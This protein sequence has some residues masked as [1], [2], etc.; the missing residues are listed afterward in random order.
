METMFND[1]LEKDEKIVKTYKPNKQKY[2]FSV[3]FSVII[4]NLWWYFMAM[5]FGIPEDGK[6]FSSKAL[7]IALGVALGLS[8]ITHLL[9]IVF[10]SLAY[11][12]RFYAYT[13]KRILIRSGIIGVDYKSLEY[14]SLTATIVTVSLIDKIVRKNTGSLVFGS[15]SSPLNG[16][17]AYMFKH[18]VKP[19]DTLREIKEVIETKDQAEQ[20]PAKEPAKKTVTKKA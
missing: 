7:W 14:K 10:A 1:I 17:G 6:K 2:W 12:K 19:Y 13:N 20:T 15:P 8:V 5:P 18:I 11:S 9:T 3:H 16:M 4:C